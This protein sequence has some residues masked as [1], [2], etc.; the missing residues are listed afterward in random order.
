MNFEEWTAF[1]IKTEKPSKKINGYYFGIFETDDNEY[2]MYLSGSKEFDANND[3]WACN[4]DF[5]PAE[6][7][8]PLPQY[9][10]LDWECVLNHI[11]ELL[12][13]FI[14]T[15]I[16]INS[17]FAKAQGIGAGFDDGSFVLIKQQ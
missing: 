4:N 9:R 12:Q 16:Y 2:M 13:N 8:L 11:I 5:E 14:I 10:G 15:D 1:I 7:Y 3:D 6:K 17:F